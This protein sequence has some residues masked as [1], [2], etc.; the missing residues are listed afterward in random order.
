MLYGDHIFMLLDLLIQSKHPF[1]RCTFSSVSL[2]FPSALPFKLAYEYT[3]YLIYLIVNW[4]IQITT[5]LQTY[6]T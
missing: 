3:V 2:S 6:F 5:M 1:M 4:K